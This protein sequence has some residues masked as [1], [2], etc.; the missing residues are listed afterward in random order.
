MA[1]TPIEILER[2]G[3]AGLSRVLDDLLDQE[4]LVRLAN[5]SALKYRGMR[6]QSQSRSRL[7]ADLAEKAVKQDEVGQAVLRALAKETAEI[8]REW[9]GLETDEKVRRLCD[10]AFLRADGNVGRHLFLLASAPEQSGLD[11]LG[12]RIAREHLLRIGDNGAAGRA[13]NAPPPREEAR[14]RRQIQERERK[15]RH[16]ESQL[17]KARETQKGTKQDLILRKGELAESRMLVERLRAELAQAQRAAQPSPASGGAHADDDAVAELTKTVRQLVAGQKKLVQRLRPAAAAKDRGAEPLALRTVQE[18][19]RQLAERG[20]EESAQRDKQL[21]SLGKRLDALR[22]DVRALPAGEPTAKPARRSRAKGPSLRVG[23][24]IDVQNMYHGARRLKGKLDFD[25]L[26]E[27]AV[28]GRRLI[29]ATAYVV[30]SEEADQSQFIDVLEKRGIEV[31]RKTLQVRADGSRKGDWDM[32]LALDILDAAGELDVVI[33]VSGDGDFTS[34]VKRVKGIGPRV[35][36]IAFP[37]A[38]AKSLVQAADSF[39]PLDRKFMIYTRAARPAGEEPADDKPAE[40]PAD[41][42]P[43]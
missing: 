31:R 22:A 3:T 21:E 10:A 7:L 11:T 26:M 43:S 32:E 6:T 38:T 1:R 25:A 15:L 12:G 35:E 37:R 39:Q 18:A 27:A 34:L 4:R 41:D 42:E 13:T 19:L 16:L 8:A 40:A 23:V 24:F 14:L 33:L 28:Q 9:E 2:L 20:A 30:E 17:S 5:A 36:V 29:K